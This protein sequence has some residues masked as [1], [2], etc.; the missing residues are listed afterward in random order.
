MYVGAQGGKLVLVLFFFLKKA[1]D[2]STEL[3]LPLLERPL[4][5]WA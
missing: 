5:V 2:S 3:P 4:Q 1:Q